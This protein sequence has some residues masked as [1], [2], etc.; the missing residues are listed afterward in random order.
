MPV[1]HRLRA[2]TRDLHDRVEGVPF[3]TALTAGDLPLASYVGLLHALALVHGCFEQA[4]ERIDHAAVRAVWSDHRRKLPLLERDLQSFAAQALPPIPVAALHALVMCQELR[5]RAAED[6]L[7]LLGYLYV[8]EGAT[9]GGMLLRVRVARHFRLPAPAGVAYLSSYGQRVKA[10]WV[11][12]AQRMNA[13]VVGV[14]DQD[15]MVAAAREA[16][17]GIE[18][19][20]AALYP[21]TSPGPDVHTAAL[22]PAAGNH[23]IPEDL[24]EIEAALR[25]GEQTWHMFPYFELRYG[26]RGRRFTRSDSAWI[27]TLVNHPL[28]TVV[29]QIRWLGRLLAARGMPQGL[30]DAHLH[31]LHRELVRAVPER[32]AAYASLLAAADDLRSIRQAHVSDEQVQALAAAFD[33]MVGDELVGQMPGAGAL[34]AL[35]VADEQAGISNAVTSL[36]GWLAE[37]ARFPE[38]WIEAVQVTIARARAQTG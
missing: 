18:T 5:W 21:L 37:P 31:N 24:R 1:M 17:G 6:P 22:N 36:E 23:A 2:E 33:G 12:F 13:A 28:P 3:A 26:A 16:Y 35:A 11:D 10:Q 34:L 38:R 20:L 9:L 25:A 19:I 8:F 30:L 32:G 14:A 7:A 29:R 4:V 15:R 27:V